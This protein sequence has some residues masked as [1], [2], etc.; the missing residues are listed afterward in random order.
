MNAL[1][2]CELLIEQFFTDV[3]NTDAWKSKHTLIIQSVSE[4]CD[5]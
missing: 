5:K 1:F 4:F 2:I 3:Y